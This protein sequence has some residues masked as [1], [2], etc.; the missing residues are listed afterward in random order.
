V[1]KT[2][3]T[4][5]LTETLEVTRGSDWRTWLR[6]HHGRKEG[7]W[8]IFRKDESG[9]QSIS[10]DEALDEALAYGWIDSIVKRIDQQKYARKFT[11]RRPWS[12]WSKSN[13]ERVKRLQ[14]E[15]R[16]TK[17]GLHAFAK[18]TAEISLLE[19]FN[20]EGVKIPSDLREALRRNKK[21]WSNFNHFAPS[22]RKRY[23]IWISAAKPPETR[24]KRIAE[25]VLLIS[26]NVKALLK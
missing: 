9:R 17:S 23:L 1:E 8:L 5:T 3:R 13:I 22:Y 19:K 10:Y 24:K 12:I 18:R 14:K 11:P 26:R 20:A 7:V 2:S 21:A 25:S 16:M 6:K 15:G 4:D